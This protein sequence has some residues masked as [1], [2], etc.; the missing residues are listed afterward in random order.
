MPW[1]LPAPEEG[2]WEHA[3]PNGWLAMVAEPLPDAEV[4]PPEA[5][6]EEELLDELPEA[7]ADESSEPQAARETAR[8]DAAASRA[9]RVRRLLFT[10]LVLLLGRA[11]RGHGV[12]VGC[13]A[14]SGPGGR[15][16]RCPGRVWV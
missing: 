3:D 1:K 4:E 10:G 7:A 9:P 11:T 12:A 6:P 13:R 2:T 16:G 15:P 8:V 5:L 14:A